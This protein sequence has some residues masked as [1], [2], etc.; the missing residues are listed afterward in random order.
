MPRYYVSTQARQNG[1]HEVHQ[2]DCNFLPDASHL[3]FLGFFNQCQNAIKEAKK[4]YPQSSGCLYCLKE[5]E[6]T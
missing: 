5:D 4:H 3:L 6:K 2:A 1:F